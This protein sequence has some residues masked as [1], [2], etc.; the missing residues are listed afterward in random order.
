MHGGV[1][2]AMPVAA[3]TRRPG[4]A[5]DANDRIVGEASRTPRW[6]PTI[7]S[8]GEALLLLVI[9][10]C[11]ALLAFVDRELPGVRRP[12]LVDLEPPRLG[13]LALVTIGDC[14]ASRRPGACHDRGLP[15]VWRPG[16]CRSGSAW[17]L[18]VLAFVRSGTAVFWRSWRLSIGIRLPSWRFPAQRGACLIR[19]ASQV[20]RWAVSSARTAM[21]SAFLVPT[22]TTRR[23]PRVR[24]V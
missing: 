8:L 5:Q 14:L 7:G 9:D 10:W 11:P 20:Q 12:A 24:A 22:S 21:P 4:S 19:S 18:G 2:E 16:A 17:R 1:N 13:V 6:T 3:E 15:G 23:L